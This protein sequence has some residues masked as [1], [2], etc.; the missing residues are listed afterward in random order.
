MRQELEEKLYKKYP[1]LFKEV[2]LPPTQSCMAFGIECSDGWYHILDVACDMIQN[3]INQR[4][5]SVFY[6]K[7]Y[8]R[9]LS[10]AINGNDKNLRYHYKKLGWIEKDIEQKVKADLEKKQFREQFWEVPPQLVFSQIKEK[11]G[12]LRIYATGGDGYCEG[13]IDMAQAWSARVCEE[14]G[15]QGKRRNSA[16]IRV[17]CDPCEEARKT[18]KFNV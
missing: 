17:L 4:R 13:V 16:W 14:C 5:S 10:Q 11:Y 18:R 9:A 7:K 2:G 8:N 15:A 12:T 3:H 1:K 6:V